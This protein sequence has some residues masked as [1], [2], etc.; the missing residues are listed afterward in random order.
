VL[1]SGALMAISLEVLCAVP[2]LALVDSTGVNV[3]EEDAVL[4]QLTQR[5]DASGL[6]T[7]DLEREVHATQ[8]PG[9]WLRRCKGQ[10]TCIQKAFEKTSIN[11]LLTFTFSRVGN[12]AAIALEWMSRKGERILVPTMVF[13][14]RKPTEAQW[15]ALIAATKLRAPV[16]PS[17]AE[18]QPLPAPRPEVLVPPSLDVLP[19]PLSNQTLSQ[20]PAAKRP[21][22]WLAVGAGVSF[23]VA[24]S[25]LV[26]SLVLNA[27][28]NRVQGQP[29][30]LVLPESEA[31]AKVATAN[32]MS[33]CAI[34]AG[35]LGAALTP[36]SI[37]LW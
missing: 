32:A 25:C 20:A 37:Y 5:F 2:G 21:G 17:I 14:G 33:V 10:L 9:H 3:V 4:L 1:V 18:V 29:P 15:S 26:A 35:G 8:K 19:Q 36:L 11:D 23:L 13:Q 6:P 12:D 30:V 31:R 28:A 16:E 22:K 34:S 7:R 24:G 27:E